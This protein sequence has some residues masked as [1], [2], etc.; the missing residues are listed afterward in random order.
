VRSHDLLP[1]L[2]QLHGCSITAMA[3]A[4]AAAADATGTPTITLTVVDTTPAAAAAL[5]TAAGALPQAAP[6]VKQGQQQQQQFG[7]ASMGSTPAMLSADVCVD[8][9]RARPSTH[10]RLPQ[11][12]EP[13]SEEQQQH[14]A[15]QQQHSEEQQQHSGEQQQHDEEQQQQQQQQRFD[16]ASVDTLSAQK[17]SDYQMLAPQL[18]GKHSYQQQTPQQQ[19][20][21]WRTQLAAK[22]KALD[23]KLDPK[24]SCCRYWSGKP[25]SC[26]QDSRCRFAATHVLGR[27]TGHYTARA[28]VLSSSAAKRMRR[29]ATV[30]SGQVASHLQVLDSSCRR[31]SSSQSSN[32][33]P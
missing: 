11:Q 20:L 10:V 2:Q 29:G 6:T 28:A 22:L 19:Q 4:A 3:A 33:L 13:A 27:P 21:A 9:N 31:R 1:V 18:A 17:G 26:A 24:L 15:E 30:L 25:D 32:L 5:P 16:F 8:S 12:H 23:A 7:F 14:E